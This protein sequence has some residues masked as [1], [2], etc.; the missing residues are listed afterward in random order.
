M[1]I[2][3]QPRDWIGMTIAQLQGN[4]TPNW[5]DNYKTIALVNDAN[6][7]RCGV[8]YNNFDSENVCAHIAIWPGARLTAAFIRAAFE[9]P[10][11]Q[12]NKR[13]ITATIARKN[14]KAIRFVRKLGFT[15]EGCL[16]DFFRDGDLMVY[17][18]LK[19]DCQFLSLPPA[20]LR[21]V[22]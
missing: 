8:V 3:A 22:A 4:L 6:E 17:G 7:F 1:R 20:E 10:F 19:A 15:Y 2:I 14:K 9:Y 11:C 13:R 5:G 16:R 12:L 18:M 21:K